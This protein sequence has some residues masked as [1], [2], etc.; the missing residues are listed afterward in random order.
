MYNYIAYQICKASLKEKR[1]DFGRIKSVYSI[2][3]NIV[4]TR[5]QTSGWEFSKQHR[6]FDVQNR[7]FYAARGMLRLDGCTISLATANQKQSVKETWSNFLGK[8][9]PRC[10]I[11]PVTSRGKG[12]SCPFFSLLPLYCSFLHVFS[13]CLGTAK[14]NLGV[15][16]HHMDDNLRPCLPIY[17]QRSSAP[18]YRDTWSPNR[19]R[20]VRMI[21]MQT[22]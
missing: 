7:E 17:L 14:F 5:T 6:S 12:S 2:C 10:V 21:F 9:P 3:I 22:V 13:V 11:S 20:R 18:S 16:L 4:V 1:N 15:H 8:F 19:D